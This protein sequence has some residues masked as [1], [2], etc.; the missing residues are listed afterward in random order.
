MR[1][2]KRKFKAIVWKASNSHVL[3]IPSD[4]IK[5]G[6]VEEGKGYDVYLV[7]RDDEGDE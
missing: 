5:H 3:T 4:Y 1:Q 2:M 7:P 6:L